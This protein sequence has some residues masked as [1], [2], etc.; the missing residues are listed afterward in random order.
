VDIRFR[1]FGAEAT[2]RLA[3]LVDDFGFTGPL[4][5]E[6]DTFVRV[7]VRY[8]KGPVTVTSGLLIA[9]M[10]EEYVYTEITTEQPDGGKPVTIQIGQHTA[11]KGHEM[12]K[13]L[14][15]ESE[16]LRAHLHHRPG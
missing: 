13:G 8:S 6:G 15:R 9:Y 4:I 3:F 11:H 10:G 1:T 7:A 12:R 5:T 14:D 16:A 2:K